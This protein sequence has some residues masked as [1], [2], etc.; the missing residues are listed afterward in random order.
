MVTAALLVVLAGTAG[1]AVYKNNQHN[2]ALSRPDRRASCQAVS[3]QSRS[4]DPDKPVSEG[5]PGA[6]VVVV[7]GDSYSVAPRAS[8]W[9]SLLGERMHWTVYAYGVGG[10]GFAN[11]GPCGGQI[12][13]TRVQHAVER[14]PTLVILEGGLNDVNYSSSDVRKG[15][16]DSLAL[17]RG[18]IHVAVIGPV[19]APARSG[20]Q[21]IDGVLRSATELAGRQYISAQQWR[22][23]FG[24]DQ[25]HLDAKGYSQFSELVSHVVSI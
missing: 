11:G 1:F 2:V 24:P 10:T 23:R 6:P 3:A 8:N 4:F 17:M 13:E 9:A 14:Q 5:G 21:R 12:F 16:E 20:T 25:L 18:V 15:L 7:V 22:L 19:S